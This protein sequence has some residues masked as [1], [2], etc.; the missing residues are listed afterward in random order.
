MSS[1]QPGFQQWSQTN[2]ALR[3][4]AP[5]PIVFCS[6]KVTFKPRRAEKYALD[7]PTRPPPMIRTEL[8]KT[9]SF[10]SK[11]VEVGGKCQLLRHS[12]VPRLWYRAE[13]AIRSSAG[14]VWL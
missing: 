8:V 3:L 6:S 4:E 10:R 2:P 5:K 11:G 7:V 1:A 14:P 12:H 13:R 9:K